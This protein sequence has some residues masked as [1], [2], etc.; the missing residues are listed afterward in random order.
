MNTKRVEI[1]QYLFLPRSQV[2]VVTSVAPGQ[3]YSVSLM[4][5]SASYT[6]S[7]WPQT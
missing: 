3:S 1:P 7:L 2:S 5:G 4:R 6:L